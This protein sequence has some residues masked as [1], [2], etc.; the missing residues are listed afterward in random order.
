[1]SL[2]NLVPAFARSHRPAANPAP[3]VGEHKTPS[4]RPQYQIDENA[5]AWLLTVVLPGVSKEGLELTVEDSEIHLFA[6]RAWKQ[7]EGWTA[8]YRETRDF[9]YELTLSHENV[10][11]LDA[12]KASLDNGILSVTLPKAEARKPRKVAVA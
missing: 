10:I 1:M 4:L 12:V 2:F 11:D 5:D 9:P 8:R 6:N 3:S 7:P